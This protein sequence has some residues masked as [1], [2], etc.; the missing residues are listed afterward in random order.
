MVMMQA[1]NRGKV[2]VGFISAYF[3]WH[4]V[5]VLLGGIIKNIRRYAHLEPC[6]IYRKDRLS[7]DG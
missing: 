2:N 3:Y 6:Y 4:S 7:N 1:P 5:G